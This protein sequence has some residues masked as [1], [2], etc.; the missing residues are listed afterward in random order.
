MRAIWITVLGL[1]CASSL[2]ETELSRAQI[3]SKY[4]R[5]TGYFNACGAK[6]IEEETAGG[7]RH[8]AILD[9]VVLARIDTQETCFD[10]VIRTAEGRDEPLTELSAS[11]NIDGASKRGVFVDEMVSVY[12][13]AYVGM[14]QTAVV[15]GVAATQYM[16]MS[17]EQPTDKIFRVIQRRGTLCC[18]KPAATQATLSI[19]N[20]RHDYGQSKGKLEMRWK[21]SN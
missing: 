17:V 2:R 19:H 20:R 7:I 14:S 12:D 1:G 9:E 18:G 16:G 10:V 8:D 11:C 5:Q 13:H 21:L 4:A 6:C 3:G 15:E